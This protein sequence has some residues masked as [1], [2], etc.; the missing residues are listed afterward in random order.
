MPLATVSLG[1]GM[2]GRVSAGLKGVLCNKTNSKNQT[3]EGQQ[4]ASPLCDGCLH[5]GSCQVLLHRCL[6]SET[7]TETERKSE[8]E[9]ET[10]R[11]RA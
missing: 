4:E 3:E 5:S 8:S 9:M 7:E 1:Y 6:C 11:E 2:V 10:D